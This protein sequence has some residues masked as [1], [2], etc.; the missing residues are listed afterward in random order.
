MQTY[1]NILSQDLHP[2]LHGDL[3][4]Q[5]FGCHLLVQLHSPLP[6]G[7]PGEGVTYQLESSST[8][9]LVYLHAN[10]GQLPAVHHGHGHG[11]SLQEPLTDI[12]SL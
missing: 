12:Q 1:Q 6:Q 5:L 2:V 7:F 10:G 4:V 11:G 9:Q 8:I 3:L